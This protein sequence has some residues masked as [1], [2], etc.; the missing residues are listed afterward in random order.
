M[1]VERFQNMTPNFITF[2]FRI[3]VKTNCYEKN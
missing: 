3:R 2:D 1:G